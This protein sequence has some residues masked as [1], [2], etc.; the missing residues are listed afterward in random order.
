MFSPTEP[1]RPLYSFC[2]LKT[3]KS[4]LPHDE[5]VVR[6]NIS[7]SPPDIDD[8]FSQKFTARFEATDDQMNGTP[9]AWQKASQFAGYPVKSTKKKRKRKPWVTNSRI[10][11]DLEHRG[12]AGGDESLGGKRTNV[13]FVGL[14]WR[15]MVAVKRR[16][17][18]RVS[19]C[20]RCLLPSAR[21]AFMAALSAL[22]LKFPAR[23]TENL[24]L[25]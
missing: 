11:H 16:C 6:P 24:L 3:T 22:T 14:L 17:T 18:A 5:I 12:S 19:L 2:F 10:L 7:Q 20:C 13:A 4:S 23:T 21:A 15:T 25:I 1:P 9:T 8:E